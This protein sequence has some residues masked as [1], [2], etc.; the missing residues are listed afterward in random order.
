MSELFQNIAREDFLRDWRSLHDS[1]FLP[2]PIPEFP[3]VMESW[4][5]ILL[6][7]LDGAELK[8]SEVDFLALMQTAIGEGDR[9]FIVTDFDTIPPY[10]EAVRVQWLP[11]ALEEVTYST[12]L[13]ILDTHIFGLSGEWGIVSYW[14]HYFAMGAGSTFMATFINRAGGKRALRERFL[15]HALSPAW[16][17]TGDAEQQRLFK[18]EVLKSV[19]WDAVR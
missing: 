9:E 14:D 6:P 12:E 7:H 18:H 17:V 1:L 19:G 13:G 11:A 2:K 10:Q 8:F 15:E 4:E 5:V 16:H 3:F